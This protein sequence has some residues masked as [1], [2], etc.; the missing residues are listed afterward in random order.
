MHKLSH[1][2]VNKNPNIKTLRTRA[3]NDANNALPP[4]PCPQKM[5]GLHPKQPSRHHTYHSK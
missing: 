1:G 3:T 2:T 4:P 5:I